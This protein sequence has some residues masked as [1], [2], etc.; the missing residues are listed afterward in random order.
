MF[1]YGRR[2]LVIPPP[3]TSA[4]PAVL[5]PA[6]GETPPRTQPEPTEP[7]PLA[8]LADPEYQVPPWPEGFDEDSFR[9]HL[10]QLHARYDMG[11][12]PPKRDR[13]KTWRDRYVREALDADRYAGRLGFLAD[14]A[15]SVHLPSTADDNLRALV[16]EAR[17]GVPRTAPEVTL[18]DPKHEPNP[19]NITAQTNPHVG[20]LARRSTGD[21][22]A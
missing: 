20:W 22:C 14:L 10:D 9:H 17:R 3:V 1:G 6:T 13:L 15:T 16:V 11:V 12:G 4:P 7:A 8:G 19:Q 18:D 21:Q 2:R 5:E